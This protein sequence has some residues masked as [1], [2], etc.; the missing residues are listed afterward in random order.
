MA[1]LMAAVA[2]DG[3]SVVLSSHVIAELERVCDHLIVLTGGKVQVAGDVEGL[4]ADHH[5]LTGP[6]DR[7]VAAGLPVVREWRAERQTRLLVRGPAMRPPAGWR[8]DPTGLEELV[9][10]YLR[11]SSTGALPGPQPAPTKLVPA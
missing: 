6:A 3:L 8:V 2:E 1:A 11:S 4:V 7:P 5:L 10:A 9:L